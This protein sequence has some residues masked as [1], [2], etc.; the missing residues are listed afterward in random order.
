MVAFEDYDYF[1]RDIPVWYK[2]W[3]SET[4]FSFLQ[5]LG[6]KEG[7]KHM[8]DMH[9]HTEFSCDSDAKMEDY[10]EKAKASGIGTICF[11]D[12]VDLNTSD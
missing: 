9:V 8:R 11:T 7:V 2:E 5:L 10:I 6:Y 3:I 4:V 1:R 12:H